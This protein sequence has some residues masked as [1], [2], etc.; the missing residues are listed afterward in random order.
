MWKNW[1]LERSE[2]ERQRQEDTC[3]LLARPSS[4]LVSSR[5]NDALSQKSKVEGDRGHLVLVF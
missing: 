4:Q 3:G 5:F 1:V 2:L